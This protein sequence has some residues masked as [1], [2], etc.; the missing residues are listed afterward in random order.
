MVSQEHIPESG[1]QSQST[2]QKHLCSQSDSGGGKKGGSGPFLAPFKPQISPQLRR[3]YC[4]FQS[5]RSTGREVKRLSTLTYTVTHIQDN[6]SQ[7]CVHTRALT[8]FLTAQSKWNAKR[9]GSTSASCTPPAHLPPKKVKKTM[10]RNDRACFQSQPWAHSA[11]MW[12]SV[13]PRIL[14]K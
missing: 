10:T 13:C 14:H 3:N 11:N 1:L 7:T 6:Q 8:R 2:H 12:S 5:L 4:L 9:W